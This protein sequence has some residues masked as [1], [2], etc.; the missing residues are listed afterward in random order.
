MIATDQFEMKAPAHENRAVL[1]FAPSPNGYLHRGHAYSALLNAEFARRLYG[2]LLLRIEDIDPQRSLPR[3]CSALEEDL[4]WLG[5][6]FEQ[7]VR[8]Q[9]AHFADYRESFARLDNLGVV[10]RCFCSRGEIGASVKR[11]SAQG[12]TSPLDPDGTP[13]YPGTCRTLKNSDIENRL[14]EGKPFQWRLDHRKAMKQKLDA[15]V[16][17]VK[18]TPWHG[19]MIDVICLPHPSGASPWHKL[20]PG[21]TLLAHALAAAKRHPAMR[22]VLGRTSGK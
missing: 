4:A 8:R 13:I 10:Y 22:E 3:Y 16:G 14:A 12:I 6:K 20:E 7:P 18:G 15:L 17:G 5:L 21:K 19:Q 9:S 11:M 1:R 2:R